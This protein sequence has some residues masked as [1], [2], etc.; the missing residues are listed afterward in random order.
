MIKYLIVLLVSNTLL[1]QDFKSVKFSEVEEILNSE[2]DTTYIVNFW[3]TWCGPCVEEIPYFE[4]LTEKYK[5]DKFKIILISMDFE[6]DVEKRLLPFLEKK[7]YKS[8]IWWLNEAK[9]NEFIGKVEEE[10]YGEIPLTLIIK[11]SGKSRFWKAGK[12]EKEELYLKVE[13]IL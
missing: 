1:A 13:E 12:W 11:G 6:S 3:A 9:Q 2:N 5:S 7:N 8:E 4:E 10:W